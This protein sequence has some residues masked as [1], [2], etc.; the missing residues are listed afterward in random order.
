MVHS[1]LYRADLCWLNTM[2]DMC[3]M[4]AQ[5]KPSISSPEGL[6]GA[7]RRVVRAALQVS[8]LAHRRSLQAPNFRAVH[9]IDAESPM[10]P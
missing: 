2:L 10:I 3:K 4:R 9:D 1:Q 5:E 6:I 8:S 7:L